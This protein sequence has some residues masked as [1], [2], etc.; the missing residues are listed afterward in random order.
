[1]A[2]RATFTGFDHEVTVTDRVLGHGSYA[3][4]LELKYMGLKCAGKKIHELLLEQGGASYTVHR[5]EEE[6]R[7][8]SQVRHPNVVQ[9]LGVH[10]QQ[11]M[12]APILVMEFF[13][14]NLTSCIEQYGI[15][16]KEISYSI[17]H[18]VALGL[19]YL[20]SQTPPIIHRDL[21]SNN[22]LLT[23]NMTAKISDLGVARILNL[24]PQQVSRITQT[25]GTPA[26]MPPEMMIA[27][28]KYDTSVDEF[29]YGVL[30]IHMFSGRWPEP[31]VGQTRFEDGQLVPVTEA[32]RREVF[33]RA[34]GNDHSL[35]DLILK[36]IDNHPQTRAHA[37][38]IVKRLAEMVLQFPASFANQLEM[39]RQIEHQEEEKQTLRSES[40]TVI[41]RKEER[42]QQVIEEAQRNASEIDRLKMNHSIETEQLQLQ[43]KDLKLK[44]R[45]LKAESEAEIEELKSKVTLCEAQITQHKGDIERRDSQIE[46]KT[47]ALQEK[48]AIITRLD[49][50]LTK[51]REFLATKQQVS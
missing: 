48:D 24:T 45:Q 5:F 44:E 42:I 43:V 7:L 46:V 4:V 34:I 9:F 35:M 23:P 36:C 40:E 1:M 49:E 22:V 20:H 51:S 33:L 15:L 38:E 50:Q 26:Y 17:L 6:C 37:I 13:P 2:E 47:R 25:P 27:N 14:N 21:S 29:S 12:P 32:E 31:Q 3:T 16:P 10:F 30:M 41:Q 28:P 8:L 19:C 39:M 11:G 18:D